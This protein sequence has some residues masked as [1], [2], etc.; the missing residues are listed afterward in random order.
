MEYTAV[1]RGIINDEPILVQGEGT[2]EDGLTIG[3]YDLIKI[4]DLF[5]P[6]ILK[7]MLITGYPNACASLD[8]SIN[9]FKGSSYTYQRKLVFNNGGVLQMTAV[10][11]LTCD[12]LESIFTV[13]GILKCPELTSSEPIIETWEPIANNKLSGLFRIT[14]KTKDGNFLSAD[15][16]S[17]YS[18][19]NSTDGQPLL[20]RYI[21][22]QASI[23]NNVL[24][25]RQDSKL[26]HSL[27]NLQ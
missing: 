11:N 6:Y 3:K 21:E 14:W 1:L 22:I 19:R 20:H 12:S 5:N 13:K 16:H 26:F 7:A 18:P 8:D 9:V 25:L 24:S 27:I 10:C 23:D 2:I 4:P 17:I 15:A